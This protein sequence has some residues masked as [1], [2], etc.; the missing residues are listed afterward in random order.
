MRL[1]H[2]GT[3]SVDNGAVEVRPAVVTD[4]VDIEEV[5]NAAWRA[6]YQELLP[7][8]VV[9]AEA[10]KRA[11]YD[12]TSAILEVT[13]HVALSCHH[14]EVVGVMQASEPQGGGRD[15]PEITML[16]V[17]PGCWGTTAA[18]DLLA[19]GTRW[20][21]QQGWPAARLRVVDAQARARRFYEREGWGPDPGLPPAHNGYF[22]LVY[23]RRDLGS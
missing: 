10:A 21:A 3:A 2:V 16:Y 5:Y 8:A 4:V 17:V 14:E 19:A 20:M 22:P 15:L 23:Y 6:A 11:S 7:P 13:S 18:R 1:R 12:W 9:E